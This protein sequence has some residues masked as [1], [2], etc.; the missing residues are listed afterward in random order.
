MVAAKVVTLVKREVEAE[1]LVDV[2]NLRALI[3]EERV[4]LEIHVMTYMDILQ[5]QLI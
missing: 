2:K 3:V 4:P 1:V 5:K